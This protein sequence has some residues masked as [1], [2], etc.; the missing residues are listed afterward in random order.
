[1]KDNPLV[2]NQKLSLQI[3]HFFSLAHDLILRHFETI[4]GKYLLYDLRK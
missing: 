4:K 3:K 1:M 2:T